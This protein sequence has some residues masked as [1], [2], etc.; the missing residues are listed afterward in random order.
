M[1]PLSEVL[2]L[3]QPRSFTAGGLDAGGTWAI[4]FTGDGNRTS[5]DIKCYAVVSGACWLEVEGLPKPLRLQAGDAIVLTGARALR[6]AS[7]LAAPTVDFTTLVAAPLN[8]GVVTYNGGGE[9]FAVGSY[10]SFAGD[11]ANILLRLLPLAAPIR[12]ATEKA[13][14]RDSLEAMNRELRTPLPGG[15]LIVQ[16]LAYLM[17]VQALRTHVSQPGEDTAGWLFA[18]ADRQIGPVLAAMH[19]D[20]ARRW[21]LA[22]LARLAGMSR[23]MFALKFKSAVGEPAIDY[24]IRWR[25]LLAA[26]RVLKSGMRIATIAES[27]GYASESAFSA[28][29]RRVIGCSPRQYARD[30]IREAK[31]R[32]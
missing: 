27:L 24:L 32:A 5:Q 8:G 26:Q 10:F 4:G 15:Y 28:A 18:L 31:E 16:Q 29:F 11:H 30:R 17:L 20:P 7:D 3:L 12:T 1:D 6:L 22:A 2:A 23:S 19:S 9:F 21:T 14:I 13:A 25:M